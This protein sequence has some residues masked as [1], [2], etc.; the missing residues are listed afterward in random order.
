MTVGGLILTLVGFAVLTVGVLNLPE[1]PTREAI[2]PAARRCERDQALA[3]PRR[4]RRP[5]MAYLL[6]STSHLAGHAPR[7]TGCPD[8]AARPLDRDRR[9][10][11]VDSTV[12]AIS[13]S[14]REPNPPNPI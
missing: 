9:R 10:R 12:A 11:F 1:L 2:R 4:G 13:E 8:G 3:P 5:G 14:H 6:S 7:R